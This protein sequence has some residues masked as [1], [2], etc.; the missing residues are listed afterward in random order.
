MEKEQRQ[1]GR[2]K[3][4]TWIKLNVD[5]KITA[6][7]AYRSNMTLMTGIFGSF[8]IVQMTIS[9]S[10]KIISWAFFKK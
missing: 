4:S 8:Q 3:I 2:E 1:V 9:K 6:S 5:F 10:V 7:H